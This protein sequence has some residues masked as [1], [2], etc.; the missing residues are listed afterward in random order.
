MQYTIKQDNTANN[1]R[2]AKNTII[3]YF[4]LFFNIFIQ[5]YTVPIVLRTLGVSDYGLYNVV[6]GIT[7]MFT[8]IGGSMASG[9]QRF[10]SFAIGKNDEV[11]LKNTFD[12]TIY[13]FICMAVVAF[14]LFEIIGLWFLNSQMVVEDGR[15]AAANWIYQFSIVSFLIALITIPYNGVV[16]AHERMDFFAYVSIGSSVLKLIAIIILPYILYDY[17]IVYG[18]LI[19]I[20]Q[21]LERLAYQ[22]FCNLNYMECRQISFKFDRDLGKQLLTYSGFN[23]IGSIATILRKQGLNIVVN[24]FFGTIVN[25][26]HSIAL[27]I[28]GILEQFIGNLYV[29]SRPQITKYYA[30]RRLDDMWNLTYRTSLLAYYLLMLIG[31]VAFVEAPTILTIWLDDY[32]DYTIGITRIFIVSMM[33]ETMINQL[34]GVFQAYNRIKKWQLYA[35]SILML[36]VPVAYILLKVDNSNV[37][38]PYYIQLLFSL[39]YVFLVLNIARREVHLS[40]PY[41]LKNVI[42]REIIVTIGVCTIL[43]VIIEHIEPS[44]LRVFITSIATLTVS[45]LLILTIGFNKSDRLII[46]DMIKSKIIIKFK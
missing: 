34:S 26:A 14:V 21:L 15:L 20:V 33:I 16:I 28:N 7:A 30:E 6:C 38:S 37:L 25:A 10:F 1:K 41:Y 31:V 24:L 22:L 27:H 9:V 42:G 35:S 18:L 40:V 32:P 36:N 5:L 45:S 43:Y 17:L 12:T 11:K 39:I 23:L 2:I 13:I 3:M 44:F 4:R 19:L 8:F 29:T 46:I